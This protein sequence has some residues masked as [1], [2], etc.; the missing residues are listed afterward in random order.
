MPK[1]SKKSL[2]KLNTCED[3]LQVLM[4][5]VIKHYDC[6]ILCGHRSI[7][8]QQLLYKYGKSHLDGVHKLSKHN[9]TPS[10]AVDVVPYPINWD[11][12]K[13]FEYFGGYVLGI[14]DI[15]YKDGKMSHRVRWG[16]NW[17]GNI[18]NRDIQRS[19]F[20]DYVHFE[21]VK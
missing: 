6:T 1:F 5:E 18:N 16:G 17:R 21:L 14:A 15:L 12:V 9:Y 7:K 2:K 3:D 4:N 10:R 13:R 8:E 19:G 11:D 20:R